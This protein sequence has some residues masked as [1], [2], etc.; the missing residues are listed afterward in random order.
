MCGGW[1]AYATSSP[2]IWSSHVGPFA[3]AR[4][5]KAKKAERGVYIGYFGEPYQ[6]TNLIYIYAEVADGPYLRRAN[7]RIQIRVPY[8]NNPDHFLL[9]EY[10]RGFNGNGYNFIRGQFGVRVPGP[11]KRNIALRLTMSYTPRNGKQRRYTGSGKAG[12]WIKFTRTEWPDRPHSSHDHRRPPSARPA[13]AEI[14]C[15]TNLIALSIS[16]ST[17]SRPNHVASKPSAFASPQSQCNTSSNCRNRSKR[18]AAVAGVSW[19]WSGRSRSVKGN[20]ESGSCSPHPVS[21]TRVFETRLYYG[22][23]A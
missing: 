2:G 13:P 21:E 8:L 16:S 19:P 1:N 20:T 18:L 10:D 4:R 6:P 17:L 3:F 11:R 14:S 22:E 5:V 9:V 7:G 12:E 15:L 23:R